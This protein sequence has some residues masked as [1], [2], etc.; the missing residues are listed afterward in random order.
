MKSF[1]FIFQ[2]FCCNYDLSFFFFCLLFRN[3]YFEEHVLQVWF[4][5][6]NNKKIFSF[7][8]KI[9]AK[10]RNFLSEDL[11]ATVKFKNMKSQECFSEK[12]YFHLFILIF[13]V[14]LYKSEV[15]K[16]IQ[17]NAPILLI[18]TMALW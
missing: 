6:F 15:M 13:I 8:Q 14:S 3:T 9:F 10:N 16:T 5:T 12:V 18:T 17:C 7:S 4:L 11:G 1:T 2:G